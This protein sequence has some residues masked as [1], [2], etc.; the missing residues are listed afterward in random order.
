MTELSHAVGDV[1][2][3][4]LTGANQQTCVWLLMPGTGGHARLTDGLE[5]PSPVVV[6]C[7]LPLDGSPRSASSCAS[8]TL[9][10]DPA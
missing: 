6:R 5:N 7:S 10:P 2:Q 8:A 1:P 9:S 4:C 3:R